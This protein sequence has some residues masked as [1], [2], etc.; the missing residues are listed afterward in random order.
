M[1]EEL[2]CLD[3]YGEDTCEG[4]VE[5]RMP[6]SGSGR[7]FP[8]CDKHWGLRLD[9]QEE[10]NRKYPDTPIAP[11]DFDPTYAGESWDEE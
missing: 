10:I 2:K 1:H 9:A 5:Y 11:A 3:D 6:L 8:R 7:A 4:R